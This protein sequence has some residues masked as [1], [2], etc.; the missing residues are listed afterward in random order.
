M[1]KLLISLIALSSISAI[2]MGSAIQRRAAQQAQGP[3]GHVV[4]QAPIAA[5][6]NNQGLNAVLAQIQKVLNS[7][8]NTALATRKTNLTTLVNTLSAQPAPAVPLSS[9]E[10]N[11]VLN[12]LNAVWKEANDLIALCPNTYSS[13]IPYFGAEDATVS[14]LKDLKFEITAI[15]KTLTGSTLQLSYTMSAYTDKY[16][17]QAATIV[18]L[19]AAYKS[20]FGWYATKTAASNGLPA[21]LGTAKWLLTPNSWTQSAAPAAQVA[22]PAAKGWFANFL[23]AAQAQTK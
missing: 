2:T 1:K 17:K 19:W 3:V 12:S 10:K 13:F 9:D 15:A 16:W 21:V 14:E 23:E 6:V 18:A 7:A 22:A 4:P 8:S 11:A 20:G 5:Q